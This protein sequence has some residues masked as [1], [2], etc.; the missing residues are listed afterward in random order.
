[1]TD[2]N[3]HLANLNLSRPLLARLHAEGF[4]RLEDLRHL[5]T[6]EICR[7]VGGYGANRLFE[8][9]GRERRGKSKRNLRPVSV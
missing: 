4:Q 6:P 8:A 7:R 5:S 2:E 1:M 3:P 9:L